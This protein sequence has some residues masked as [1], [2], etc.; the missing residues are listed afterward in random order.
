ML[1]LHRHVHARQPEAVVTAGTLAVQG[2]WN[3]EPH[4]LDDEIRLVKR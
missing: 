2:R 4:R 3:A 1:A